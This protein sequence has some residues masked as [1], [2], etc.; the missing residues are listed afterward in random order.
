MKTAI[1][2][3][4]SVKAFMRTALVVSAAHQALTGLPTPPA[5][6]E[7]ASVTEPRHPIPNGSGEFTRSLT[8]R[9]P[10]MEWTR[11]MAKRFRELVRKEALGELQPQEAMEL[12]Q[13]TRDRRHLLYPRSGKEVLWEVKQRELTEHLIK[14]LREY[15]EF[16]QGAHPTRPAPR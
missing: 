11:A 2:T 13:L 10:A 14:A 6:V 12:E 1:A 3:R 4:V 8:Y 7:H 5:V 15:V 9:R 16:H